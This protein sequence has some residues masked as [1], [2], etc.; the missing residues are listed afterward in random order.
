MPQL[1]YDKLT[2]RK[3]VLSFRLSEFSRQWTKSSEE[4]PPLRE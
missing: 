4:V 3:S 1:S 2:D